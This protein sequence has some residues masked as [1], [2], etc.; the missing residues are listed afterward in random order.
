MSSS[1]A[2]YGLKC[3]LLARVSDEMLEVMPSQITKYPLIAGYFFGGKMVENK[4]NVVY[5]GFLDPKI[6]DYWNISE[7][8]NKPILLYNNRK[9]HVIDRHLEQFGSIDALDKA[10]NALG[11]IIRKPDYVFYND[12]TKGLEYYKKIDKN[13]CVVV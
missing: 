7:H 6:A 13:I 10:Y 3:R 8:K 1:I 9:Y 4:N 5:V 11:T 2:D 12:S